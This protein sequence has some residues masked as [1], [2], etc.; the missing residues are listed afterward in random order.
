LN[1][2]IIALFV[3]EITIRQ[4]RP[5]PAEEETLEFGKPVVYVHGDTHSFRVDKPLVGSTS[6]RMIENFTRVETF[7]WKNTHW[8]RAIVDF[9][10]P[11]IFRF[12]QQIVQENLV[13]H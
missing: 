6:R 13:E 10:D 5:T 3:F 4:T 11:N 1:E 7:G 8:I 9:A 2:L 12:R